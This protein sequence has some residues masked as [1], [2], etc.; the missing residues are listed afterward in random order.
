[1]PNAKDIGDYAFAGQ[2]HIAEVYIADN[3][4]AKIGK[5][6]F[7]ECDRLT[8][9]HLSEQLKELPE[10]VFENDVSLDR[11]KLPQELEKS[12]IMLFMVV[13]VLI[14]YTFLTMLKK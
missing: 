3:N 10:G 11:L 14:L 6:A 1:M 7:A 2:G 13:K 5:Y 9:I 8:R 12:V 4:G